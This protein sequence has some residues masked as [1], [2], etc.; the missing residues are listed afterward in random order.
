MSPSAGT[1]KPPGKSSDVHGTLMLDAF[2][3]DANV[4]AE[5]REKWLQS[6]AANPAHAPGNP[7][8]AG[9]SGTLMMGSAQTL[10]PV[11]ARPAIPPQ[12]PSESQRRIRDRTSAR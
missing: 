12:P 11:T 4:P 7:P 10:S 3:H 2:M 8:P 5:V 9:I 6:A 1:A